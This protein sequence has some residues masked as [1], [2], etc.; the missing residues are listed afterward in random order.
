MKRP[1]SPPTTSSILGLLLSKEEGATRFQALMARG[2]GPAPSGKYRHWG[3]FRHAPPLADYSAEE[4]WLAVRTSRD[5]L[6][7][8]LPLLDTKSHPFTVAMPAPVLEFLHRIDRDASGNVGGG[9]VGA[10]PITNTATRDTYL[11]KSIVEEAISSSQLEGAST[12]RRVAKAMI[13]EGRPAATRSERMILNN[14]RGM[15]LVR[16]HRQGA[17]TPEFVFALQRMLTESTMDDPSGAGRFRRADEHIVVEDE[18]GTIL[19]H[20]PHADEL[21]QRLAAMCDFANGTSDTEF[22]PPVIRAILLHFWLAYDHPFVDGNGRTARALFYW[23]MARSGYWLCEYVSIS[24]ILR[25]ARGAYARSY[26][27]T[28]SDSNDTTYFV[29]HQLRTLVRAIEDLHEYL[30]RKTQ[31]MRDI[32]RLVRQTSIAQ[33]NLNPR[34]LA[35]LRHALNTPS[36]QYTVASHQRSHGTSYQTARTDLLRMA[37]L[38]LLR[39]FKVSK[40]FAFEP[41]GDLAVRLQE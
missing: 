13:Q 17:L 5:A 35:L 31:Q 1:D 19:H 12:T 26:L 39:Q 2:L 22:L 9:F 4:Q 41:A 29:L 7:R 33:G 40:A 14:Y 11:F 3:N 30:A 27:Y 15:L 32:E 24:R 36:A 6:A 16:D 28:E 38:G 18:T 10:E 23:S 8:P 21:P 34:Q 25:K 20:P 37:E